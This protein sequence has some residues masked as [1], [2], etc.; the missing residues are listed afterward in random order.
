MTKSQEKFIRKKDF[1]ICID[2]D[3]CAMDTMDLKHKICF[4]PCLTEEWDLKEKREWALK[5]WNEIN[6]YTKTRGINRFKGLAMLLGELALQGMDIPGTRELTEWVNAAPELSNASVEEQWRKTGH[7]IWKQTLDWSEKV[8]QKI[9]QLPEKDKK[10]FE[11]VVQALECAHQAADVVIV[12]SANGQAVMEEWKNQGLL[13][14]VDHVFSQD[15]GTKAECIRLLLEQGY[16]RSQALM[17]G[18][19]PGDYQAAKNNG[20]LFFPILVN[21]EERSWECFRT[22]GIIRL[23]E[24]KFTEEYQEK[25]LQEFS[26][27]LR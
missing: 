6:L 16:E 5:R 9:R 2:S 24:K 4:G 12:S 18:D 23:K 19:A 3:G 13:P 1:L 20:I 26:E 8:N 10:A 22:E 7:L 21:K 15:A 27:N 11:G 25:L 17:T 14:H